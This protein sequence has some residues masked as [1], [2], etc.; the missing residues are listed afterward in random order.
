MKPSGNLVGPS[1][2]VVLW[3]LEI[4]SLTGA[5]R[6]FDAQILA[7]RSRGGVDGAAAPV[8]VVLDAAT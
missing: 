1:V 4:R 6:L 8:Q 5:N 3:L 7:I 2:V